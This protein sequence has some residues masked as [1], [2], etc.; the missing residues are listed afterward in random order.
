M[1]NIKKNIGI[2]ALVSA[3]VIIAGVAS[4]ATTLPAGAL[5]GWNGSNFVATGTPQLYVGG[6]T[7]TSSSAT[8]ILMG[9]TGIGSS[10]PSF[11]LGVQGSA[12]FSGNIY[13]AN[14]TATGTLTVS[15]LNLT[16][17]GT[18]TFNGDILARGISAWQYLNV[19]FVQ[20]TS[21]TATSTFAGALVAGPVAGPFIVQQGSGKVSMASSSPWGYLS[22]QPNALGS[23]VPEFVIGSSTATHLVVDGAGRVGI[24]LTNPSAALHIFGSVAT[25]MTIERNS[26]SGSVFEAK[27]TSGSIFFGHPGSATNIF[28]I[29]TTND[30]TNQPTTYLSITSGGNAGIGS[31][32]PN[33]KFSVVG[34]GSFDDFVRASYIVATSTTASQIPY[35]SS[36]ALTATIVY[37]PDFP[38]VSYATS[39]AWTGT[40]TLPLGVSLRGQTWQIQACYTD[41]GTLNISFNDGTNRMNMIIA[42]TTAGQ[43]AITTNS[44]IFTNGTKMYLDVGTPASSPTKI[45]CSI[46]RIPS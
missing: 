18:T 21:T 27:N 41:V 12:L 15:A 16:N 26:T 37:T 39:T 11:T 9:N 30:L 28:G 23:G 34:P 45:S 20:A 31:T 10:T 19:P 17:S 44:T 38:S 22:I 43:N 42:S 3:I 14:I 7:A 33:W 29:G 5:L 6:I 25:M 13:A 2:S 4:A 40:T 8:N 46:K 35:A 1:K 24:G 36:T 32:S